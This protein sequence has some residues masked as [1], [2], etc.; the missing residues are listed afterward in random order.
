MV[1]WCSDEQFLFFEIF[2]PKCLYYTSSLYFQSNIGG[3]VLIRHL[4][5][6]NFTIFFN[7]WITKKK[8]YPSISL[9][10]VC[11]RAWDGRFMDQFY[12]V[13]AIICRLSV[14]SIA[15]CLLSLYTQSIAVIQTQAY[16]QRWTRKIFHHSHGV[17]CWLI[18][19]HFYMQKNG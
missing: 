4:F 18:K 8:K 1:F 16:S 19:I 15:F 3:Q 10:T 14:S 12:F 11:L 6:V 17:C 13:L 2:M 7:F 9:C 5:L